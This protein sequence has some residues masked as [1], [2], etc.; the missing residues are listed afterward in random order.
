M[1]KRSTPLRAVPGPIPSSDEDAGRGDAPA[2]ERF[3]PP[4]LSA[5]DSEIC[6]AIGRALHGARNVVL[7]THVNPDGDGLGA[8]AAL[9]AHLHARGVRVRILNA[10]PPPRHLRFL[11]TESVPLGVFRSF[12]E[13][14]LAEVDVLVMLDTGLLARLGPLAGALSTM[15]ALRICIDHHATRAE[16]GDLN[17]VD[18]RASSTAELVYRLLLAIGAELDLA[19][20]DPLYVGLAFDTGSFAYSNT[21]RSAHIMAADLIAHGVDPAALHERIFASHSPARMRLWGRALASLRMEADGRIAWMAV[22]RGMFLETGATREDL[23]GLAEQGRR[24][25]GVEIAML[26]RE[27]E[28]GGTK[29]SFRSSSAAAPLHPP[30]AARTI[31]HT[32]LA[33]PGGAD[34]NALAGRFGGGGHVNA[35]GATLDL[36]LDAAM[37]RVLEETRRFLESGTAP[38]REKGPSTLVP[39]AGAH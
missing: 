11:E 16:P 17:F 31:P 20:A 15:N 12:E 7:T 13:D 39:K 4:P 30:G 5:A 27:E 24:I 33:Q 10:D 38:D 2:G 34:V 29:V 19:V 3:V 23:E 28:N 36:P 14:G 8:Q 35:A 37:S 22:D 9:A 26:F 6:L 25:R 32:R 1:L 18:P 21:T